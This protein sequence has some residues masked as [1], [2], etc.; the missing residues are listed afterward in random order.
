MPCTFQNSRARH[1][2]QNVCSN[3]CCDEKPSYFSKKV[4]CEDENFDTDWTPYDL[5]ITTDGTQPTIAQ[6]GTAHYKTI[7]KSL[8]IKF[9]LTLFVSNPGTGTYL[10][11][12]PDGYSSNSSNIGTFLTSSTFAGT[13]EAFNTNMRLLLYISQSVG[14]PVLSSPVTDL[15]NQTIIGDVHIRLD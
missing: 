15:N 13:I 6:S 3:S 5:K 12:L 10:F 2:T 14:N 1:T 8:F 11:S 9:N 7:G 4:C